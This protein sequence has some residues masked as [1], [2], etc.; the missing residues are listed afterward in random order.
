VENALHGLFPLGAAAKNSVFSLL[1]AIASGDASFCPQSARQMRETGL[2][3][4]RYYYHQALNLARLPI[5]PFP[6]RSITR[7][8]IN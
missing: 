8:K 4:A 6:Q 1:P 5:P 2:E 3:P 7:G